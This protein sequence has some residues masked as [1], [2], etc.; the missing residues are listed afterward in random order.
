MKD[1]FL[2]ML[3]SALAR[4]LIAFYGPYQGGGIIKVRAQSISRTMPSRALRA[5]LRAY[6]ANRILWRRIEEDFDYG[7][8]NQ[9]NSR[10]SDLIIKMY[11]NEHGHG[12]CAED[13]KLGGDSIHDQQRGLILP[14][15]ERC[16]FALPTQ[17]TVVEIGTGNGDVLAYL[18]EK[19]QGLNFIGLDFNVASANKKHGRVNLA[20]TKGYPLDAIAAS[21]PTLAFASSTMVCMPG[22]ELQN[23]FVTLAAAGCLHILLNEPHWY[24]L[25]P[26]SIGDR[27]SVHLEG[28]IWYHDYRRYLERAGFQITAFEDKPYRAPGSGRPDIV[29]TLL[30]GQRRSGDITLGP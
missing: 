13:Y 11:N 20:F 27:K 24:G 12:Y 15:L 3:G 30:A 28:A 7:D 22:A 16:L 14:L 2:R 8:R 6:L 4:G 5:S 25:T 9:N 18:A 17:S 29:V 21:R 26:R 19:Y 10:P 23:Y 1:F